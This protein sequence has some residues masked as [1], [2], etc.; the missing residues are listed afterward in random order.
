MQ[1]GQ[2]FN[3]GQSGDDASN[4]NTFPAPD[5][6]LPA[7]D[8]TP[9]PAQP[10]AEE[11]EQV[12]PS[13]GAPAEAVPE[14]PSPLI[15]NDNEGDVEDAQDRSAQS[16][17][18]DNKGE[19]ATPPPAGGAGV[20]SPQDVNEQVAQP[21]ASDSQ[22]D[23]PVADE[24]PTAAPPPL[25]E[26]PASD[27]GQPE[28]G[29]KPDTSPDQ[30]GT[31]FSW[32]ASEYIEHHHS[33][34]W[35]MSLGALTLGFMAFLTVVLKEILSAIVVLLMAVSVVVY[36]HRKPR[37]LQ[38]QVSSGGINIG[39]KFY[40]YNEFK[41]FAVIGAQSVVSIE[42]DPVKRFMPRLSMLIDQKQAPALVD[43]LNQHLPH[44]DR[45]PE[46]IDRLAHSLKF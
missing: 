39:S 28:P 38:Y 9:P 26:E 31:Q 16:Q 23:E 19:G 1:P 7:Q 45:D 15:S 20:A 2:V 33:P 13:A 41:S 34:S 18:P 17:E 11:E 40:G 24:A 22:A 12:T 36:A 44:E 14:D 6:P 35:Y 37:S 8:I 30:N 46:F 29:S 42:L 43:I 5:T 10:L 4:D 27:S 25:P 21:D 32:E 3:P